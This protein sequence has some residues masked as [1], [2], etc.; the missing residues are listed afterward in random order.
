LSY[1]A[2]TQTN[3]RTDK[4]KPAKTI[5][6]WR[7]QKVGTYDLKLKLRLRHVVVESVPKHFC[8]DSKK[9]L[10]YYN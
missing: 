3:K 1:P 8:H 2:D 6:P 4:Q 9:L 7:R 5:P 10:F